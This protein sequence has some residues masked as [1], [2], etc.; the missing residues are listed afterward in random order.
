MGEPA[1]SQAEKRSNLLTTKSL[2]FSAFFTLICGNS[3]K[4]SN[5]ISLAIIKP[6]QKSV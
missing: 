5:K 1:L 3:M 6:I 2:F 4:F